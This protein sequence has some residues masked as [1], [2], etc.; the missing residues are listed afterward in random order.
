MSWVAQL[1]NSQAVKSLFDDECDLSFVELHD[2]VLLREGPV[3]RLR[4]DVPM[5][6][7]TR[8]RKW[9]EG[10]NTTQFVL[11]AWGVESVSI[12]GWASQITGEISVSFSDNTQLIS[13][14]GAGCSIKAAFDLLRVERITGYVNGARNS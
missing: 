11:A 12:V 14:V 9:S 1:E 7:A 2:A 3:L 13:F 6:P 5:I 10:A 8:N 4:F